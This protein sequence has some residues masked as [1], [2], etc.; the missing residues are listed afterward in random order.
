MNAFPF[1]P[2]PPDS[3]DLPPPVA[4]PPA[5][6]SPEGAGARGPEEASSPEAA[7]AD[8]DAGAFALLE[9]SQVQGDRFVL[10]CRAGADPFVVREAMERQWREGLRLPADR[11]EALFDLMLEAMHLRLYGRYASSPAEVGHLLAVASGGLVD[12]GSN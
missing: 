11:A 8:G 3:P 12:L 6:G 1:P 2:V 4:S 10:A 9:W 5:G 7:D